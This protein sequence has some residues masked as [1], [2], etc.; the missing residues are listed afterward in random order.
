MKLPDFTKKMQTR[1]RDVVGL[2]PDN[3][4]PARMNFSGTATAKPWLLI[5]QWKGV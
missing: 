5:C 2:A 4:Q 1:D 3:L